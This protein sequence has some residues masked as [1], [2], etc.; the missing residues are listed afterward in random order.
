MITKLLH[1]GY[2][3][4]ALAPRIEDTIMLA[5]RQLDSKAYTAQIVADYTGYDPRDNSF[6]LERVARGYG[7]VVGALIL[8][9]IVGMARKRWKF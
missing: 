7:P 8:S 5:Q 4:L 9:K 1:G 6:H 2:T 3:A